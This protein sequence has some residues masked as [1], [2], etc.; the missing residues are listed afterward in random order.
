MKIDTHEN[1]I[2]VKENINN[3]EDFITSLNPKSNVQL[4]GKNIIID[5][6]EFDGFCLEKLSLFSELATIFRKYNNSFV[7]VNNQINLNEIPYD[8][9]VV[10]S[11]QEAEDIV[12]METIEREL[13]M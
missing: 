3:F 5:L 13:G 4:S 7:I 1:F 12:E 9:L 2:I 10:P 11:L 8:I 6:L